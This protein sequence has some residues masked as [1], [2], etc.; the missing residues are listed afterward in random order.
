MKKTN[1]DPAVKLT[2]EQIHLKAQEIS[3][4][5]GG[6]KVTPFCF[7]EKEEDG[8]VI[9]YLREP[10]LNTKIAS[11]D[12]M[13]VDKVFLT[14]STLLKSLLIK[15]HSDSR[16]TDGHSDHDIYYMGAATVAVSLVKAAQNVLKKTS[17]NIMNS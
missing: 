12:N 5:L 14:G 8:Q 16:I 11:L 1:S 17:M 3:V 13:G 15:E 2:P 7:E 10:S 9:G 4:S 6:S